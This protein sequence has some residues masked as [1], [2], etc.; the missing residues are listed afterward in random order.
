MIFLCSFTTLS[1]FKSC[2][3]S[4]ERRLSALQLGAIRDLCQQDPLLS[5]LAG[6]GGS[7]PIGIETL[8]DVV[9]QRQDESSP[10]GVALAPGPSAQLVV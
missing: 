10:P 4:W 7:K 6:Q 1:N 2:M 5:L 3:R 8:H 9:F